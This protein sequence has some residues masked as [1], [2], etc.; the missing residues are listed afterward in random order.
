MKKKVIKE[1]VLTPEEKMLR[2]Y[3]R[4]LTIEAVVK[5]LVLGL[6][7]GFLLSILVS[8]IS[9][10][11]EFNAI[12]ISLSLWAAASIGFT[13]LF[14]FKVFRTTLDKTASRVDGMGLDERVI[15]MIEFA[16]SDN[17]IAQKQ[18]QDTAAVLQ[19]VT[20][21]RMKFG[22]LKIFV[23][24]ASLLAAIAVAAV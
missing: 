5:S 20:P 16:E 15:T 13:L 19:T 10:A 12:W 11:T 7:A 24:F 9:F 14:Y 2:G 23:I 8:I 18:R 17:V 6:M 21:K 4:K 1:K 3:Q 22:G